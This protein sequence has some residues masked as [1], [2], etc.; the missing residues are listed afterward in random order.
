MDRE[1]SGSALTQK[2][3]EI[4]GL[5][6]EYLRQLDGLSKIFISL[7]TAILGLTLSLIG[8]KLRQYQGI[9]LIIATW[10]SLL[11]TALGGFIQVYSFS[12]RFRHKADYLHACLLTD[13]VLET[14][15]SDEK[16]DEFIWKT[17]QADEQFRK[18]YYWCTGSVLAQGIF[19]LLSFIFFGLFIWANFAAK[20]A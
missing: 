11:M 9:P 20:S 1:K 18:N 7:S 6:N 16:L 2:Y 13:T 4:E 3:T 14:K 12:K 10:I 8:L 15:G 5:Q 17:H 19:L